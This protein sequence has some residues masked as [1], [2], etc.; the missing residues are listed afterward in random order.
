MRRQITKKFPHVKGCLGSNKVKSKL[1]N[2]L[3]WG[4]A[5]ALP[6][7]TPQLFVGDKRI[8]DED[9]DL[10]LEFTLTAMLK[11]AKGL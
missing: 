7:L 11:E 2:S 8:C 4:V 1:R 10:G 5:N 3:R 9:T 6:V